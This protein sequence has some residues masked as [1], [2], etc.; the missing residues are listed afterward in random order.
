MTRA[1][2]D[3]TPAQRKLRTLIRCDHRSILCAMLRVNIG[4]AT[5]ACGVHG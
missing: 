5:E 3:V 1:R 4:D 2:I